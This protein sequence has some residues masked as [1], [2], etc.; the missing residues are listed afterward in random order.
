MN[1]H[2]RVLLKN[3]AMDTWTAP[4]AITA[5]IMKISSLSRDLKIF[6]WNRK[7]IQHLDMNPSIVCLATPF[8]FLAG[9]VAGMFCMSGNTAGGGGGGFFGGEEYYPLQGRGYYSDIG[10]YGRGALVNNGYTYGRRAIW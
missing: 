9:W 8:V 1:C 7:A 5:T 10:G 2:S 4:I 3:L 6:T